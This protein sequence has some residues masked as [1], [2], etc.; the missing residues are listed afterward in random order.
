[1]TAF[2]PRSLVASLLADAASDQ[3]D[4][5]GFRQRAARTA[6][7]LQRGLERQRIDEE[8]ARRRSAA[9]SA[10]RYKFIAV[11]RPGGSAS[12][13]ITRAEFDRLVGML[14]SPQAVA[15]LA[16]KVAPGYRPESGMTRSAYVRKRLL[17]HAAGRMPPAEPG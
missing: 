17:R 4:D 13:S 2:N 3:L 11:P 15:G 5:A 9:A 14:G 6:Q 1:M 16:R 8:A 10:A 7:R 12:V